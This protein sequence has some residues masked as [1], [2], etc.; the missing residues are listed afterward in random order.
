[1]KKLFTFLAGAALLGSLSACSSDEPAKGPENGGETPNENGAYLSVRLSSAGNAFGRALTDGGYQDSDDDEMEH[2]VKHAQFFFYDENGTFVLKGKTLTGLN[3]SK[4]DEENENIEYIDKNNIIV[5]NKL[6]ESNKY[7]SYML[8]VLNAPS[9]TAAGTLTE[10]I[11]QLANYQEQQTLNEESNDYFVMSTSSYFGKDKFHLDKSADLATLEEPN[12]MQPK[13]PTATYFTT[14]IPQ[15]YYKDSEDAAKETQNAVEVYVERLAAKVQ[16]ANSLP[17]SGDKAPVIIG[18]GASERKLYPV[19]QSVGSNEH[20]EGIDVLETTLYIEPLAWDLNATLLKSHVMKKLDTDN[21]AWASAWMNNSGYH[22]SHWAISTIYDK[23][24]SLVE[25]LKD[26]KGANSAS[27]ADIKYITNVYKPILSADGEEYIKHLDKKFDTGKAYCNE[28]TNTVSKIFGSDASNSELALVD[29]RYVTHA[30]L[31]ARICDKD[32]NGRNMVQA[33]PIMYDKDAYISYILNSINNGQNKINLFTLE[34]STPST[35]TTGGTIVTN[36]YKTIGTSFFKIVPID[37]ISTKTKEKIVGACHIEINKEEFNKEGLTLYKYEDPSDLT[38]EPKV[39]PAEELPEILESLEKA[40]A[41]EQPDT[42]A[43]PDEVAIMCDNGLCVYYVP[44]EH[45]A[46]GNTP[47][48]GYYGVVRNH[49]YKL[50]I[51][52]LTKPG[53]GVWEPEHKVE[54]L[55]PDD[56]KSKSYYLG[57]RINILSWKIVNQ[58]VKL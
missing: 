16:V 27:T 32:G 25:V 38:K 3:V 29:A 20:N 43:N 54:V 5:L 55:I 12:K 45:N 49:W 57:A 6:T 13:N 37:V 41:D 40:L 47:V 39:V 7:P 42:I 35:G 53:H 19:T 15:S 8:T 4:P 33:G 9:F 48:E 17:T 36:K 56:P 1:M 11:E 14:Y 58:S 51:E 34:S 46:V 52:E 44:I 28:N 21:T 10:A 2:T 26:I 30:V 24:L 50:S 31:L 23:E 18:T 22:R